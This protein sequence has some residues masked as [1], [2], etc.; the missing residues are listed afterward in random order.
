M[1]PQTPVVTC[2]LTSWRWQGNAHLLT[3]TSLPTGCLSMNSLRR[4]DGRVRRWGTAS[5]SGGFVSAMPAAVGPPWVSGQTQRPCVRRRGGCLVFC[6][7]RGAAKLIPV[8][9]C[10]LSNQWRPAVTRA[11]RM[12]TVFPRRRL[13]WPAW[14]EGSEGRGGA[15]G[16]G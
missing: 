15:H 9:C 7:A 14:I 10:Q 1:C 2:L 13:W 11:Q 12:K 6:A 8:R 5:F 16:P 4:T 3:G